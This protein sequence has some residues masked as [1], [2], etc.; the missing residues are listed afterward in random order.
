[1]HSFQLYVE[2]DLPS[3]SNNH[4]NVWWAQNQESRALK[5]VA[6]IQTYCKFLFNDNLILIK[7]IWSRNYT[8]IQAKNN[9]NLHLF[10]RAKWSKLKSEI[11]I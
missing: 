10:F 11:L 4:L 5:K 6:K 3:T 1:M 9:N 2:K 8:I 7:L